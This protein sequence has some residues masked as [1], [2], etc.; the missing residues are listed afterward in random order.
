MK[1]QKITALTTIAALLLQNITA[2][3]PSLRYSESHFKNETEESENSSTSTD[4]NDPSIDTDDD[5]NPVVPGSSNKFTKTDEGGGNSTT[6][7]A[8]KENPTQSEVKDYSAQEW[9]DETSNEGDAEHNNDVVKNSKPG[10]TITVVAGDKAYTGTLAGSCTKCNVGGVYHESY[11]FFEGDINV[12]DLPKGN[13]TQYSPQDTP[14]S[15]E[16]PIAG[17]KVDPGN[18]GGSSSSGKAPKSDVDGVAVAQNRPMTEQEFINLVNQELNAAKDFAQKTNQSGANSRN[19]LDSLM[20]EETET[21]NQSVGTILNGLPNSSGSSST[22]N[23]SGTPGVQQS[24]NL[25]KFAAGKSSSDTTR[26]EQLGNELISSAQDRANQGDEEGSQ[27]RLK[28]ANTVANAIL[29]AS[30]LPPTQETDQMDENT[31][32]RSRALNA[33]LELLETGNE[34]D[35]AGLPKLAEQSQGAGAKL[36]EVALTVARFSDIVDVP[37]TVMEAFAGKTIGFDPDTGMPRLQDI[38]ATDQAVAAVSLGITAAVSIFTGGTGATLAGIIKRTVKDVT[39]SVA[40]T[41]SKREAKI[42]AEEAAALIRKTADDA[43]E[44]A[45][46]IGFKNADD[47]AK[48]SDITARFDNDFAHKS[49]DDAS[50]ANKEYTDRGKQPPYTKGTKTITFK[51]TKPTEFVRVHV[52]DNQQG[53]FL[54]KESDVAGLT[55]EQ[56]KTKFALPQVPTHISKVTVPAGTTIRVG[57]TGENFGALGGGVQ[58]ELLDKLLADAFGEAVLL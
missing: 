14:T 44:K 47:A 17:P 11:I 18:G 57:H 34:L 31:R 2:C 46:K 41:V 22:S 15:Q 16:Q 13:K 6:S 48:H 12:T 42:A 43:L 9:S 7:E 27:K 50:V 30:Q 35:K 8:D 5:G 36:L 53:A 38:S 45:E 10:D 49:T 20:K 24:R 23:D 33:G 4:S 40:K 21:H 58:F 51:T 25:L 52:A 29:H 1:H 32:Q 55:P 54:M 26:L 3:A 56:I 37:F 39:E 28:T 19:E